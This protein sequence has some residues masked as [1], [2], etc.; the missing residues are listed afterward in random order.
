MTRWWS[1]P[2]RSELVLKSVDDSDVVQGVG[3]AVLGYHGLAMGVLKPLASQTLVDASV[4][5][6]ALNTVNLEP[7]AKALA[8]ATKPIMG[9]ASEHYGELLAR[10]FHDKAVATTERLLVTWTNTGMAWPHAIERAS[11]VHGV[12]MERLAKYSAVMKTVRLFR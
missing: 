6:E 1:D 9:N 4:V 2:E 7:I 10:A 8:Q 11:E 5:S 3:T 12:P